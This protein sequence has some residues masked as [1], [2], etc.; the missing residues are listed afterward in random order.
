M[1]GYC[2]AGTTASDVFMRIHGRG[3]TEL[4]ATSKTMTDLFAQVAMNGRRFHDYG[5]NAQ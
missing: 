5:R 4:F 3:M 1:G 2:G